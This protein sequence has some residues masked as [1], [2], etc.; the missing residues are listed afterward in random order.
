VTP[1]ES[2]LFIGSLIVSIVCG[3]LILRHYSAH[4]GTPP[5]GVEHAWRRCECGQYAFTHP[6]RTHYDDRRGWRHRPDICQP[7]DEAI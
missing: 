1:A 6:S 2:W 7:V 5:Q 4:D 3:V